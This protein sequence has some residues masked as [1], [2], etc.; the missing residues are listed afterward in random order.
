MSASHPSPIDPA[1]GHHRETA[2]KVTQRKLRSAKP[3][4]SYHD[5]VVTIA[6]S[7][8]YFRLASVPLPPSVNG[9]Y[10]NVPGK[11]RVDTERLTSWKNTTGLLVNK[12]KVGV[13]VG[14][15]GLELL[16][17]QDM[18]GDIDN[19]AKPILDLFVSLGVT[20]DDRFCDELIIRRDAEVEPG[21]CTVEIS[22]EAR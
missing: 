18:R 17:P 9:A 7:R 1:G 3:D 15:Y 8:N 14:R 20:P 10:K 11:G 22:G 6:K 5:L 4:P 12:A 21:F 13:I 19:R 2:K 16:V